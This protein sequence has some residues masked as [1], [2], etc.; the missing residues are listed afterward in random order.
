METTKFMNKFMEK[1]CSIVAISYNLPF[2]Y[3]CWCLIKNNSKVI[4][5]ANFAIMIFQ[6]KLIELGLLTRAVS[7][8]VN[9]N[10]YKKNNPRLNRDYLF[11]CCQRH[12]CSLKTEYRCNLD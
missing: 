3:K 5:L 9:V 10:F 8:V 1:S 6:T 4:I 12:F 2:A 7:I 11:F